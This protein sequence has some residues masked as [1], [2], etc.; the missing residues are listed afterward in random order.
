MI[1]RITAFSLASG[2]DP[3][4]LWQAWLAHAMALKDVPALKKYVINRVSKILPNRDGSKP[5]AE[6]YGIV[7]MWFDN[8]AAQVE[9]DRAMGEITKGLAKDEFGPMTSAPRLAVFVEEKIIK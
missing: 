3:E 1:K 6:Y 5:S 4:K 8:E 7:E 9:A 2:E